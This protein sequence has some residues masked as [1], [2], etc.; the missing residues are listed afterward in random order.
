VKVAMLGS[1]SRGNAT[2]V[3]SDSTRILVDAGFSGRQLEG[4]LGQLGVAPEAL[5][6]VVVTHDHSDHTRGIGVFARKFGTPLYLTPATR[7]VC[8]S[9][10]RG[11]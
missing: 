7:A 10:L 3:M 5:D 9:L 1:G 11:R 2:L 4:R 8:A 6:A